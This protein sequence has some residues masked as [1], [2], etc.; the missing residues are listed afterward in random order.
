MKQEFWLFITLLLPQY[1]DTIIAKL[2]KTGYEVKGALPGGIS[3][4]QR[5]SDP[6]ML[7]CLSVFASDKDC[8]K[9]GDELKLMFKD[10]KMK[11]YSYIVIQPTSGKGH[12][13]PSNFELDRTRKPKT[14][15]SKIE[16]LKLIS[17]PQEE[18]KTSE[19][20]TEN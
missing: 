1:A 18:K 15:L 10:E 20:D 6:A 16:H 11:V 17:T 7:C 3:L 13:G 9:V 4:E 19:E 12:V 2:V 8:V 14:D 5:S